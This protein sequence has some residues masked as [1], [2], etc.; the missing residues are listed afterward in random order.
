MCLFAGP[1]VKVSLCCQFGCIAVLLILTEKN[2]LSEII[3]EKNE[4]RP[5]EANGMEAEL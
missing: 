5:I 2:S 4:R 3:K 1:D